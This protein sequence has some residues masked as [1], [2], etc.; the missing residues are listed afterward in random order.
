MK[1]TRWLA[2]VFLVLAISAFFALDLNQYFTLHYLQQSQSD[3]AR[4]YAE[5]PWSMRAAYFVLYLTVAALSLPG[6]ALLTLAGGA[7]FGFWWGLVLVSFAS[8]MGATVSF[9]V[10]RWLL[11]DW[12]Q[13]RFATQLQEINAGVQRAG[14]LYLLSLRL[15]PVV[16]FFLI[17]LTMGLTTLRSWTFYGVSQAGML[18]GT[19]VFVNAGI[20]LGSLQRLSDAA[21]PGLLGSLALIGLMPLVI[22][23]AMRHAEKLRVFAPW[24]GQRPQRFDR[25][26]IVIGAG[27]GGLVSA[28]IAAAVKAKVTLVE[29]RQMGGDCL[30]TGCVPSKALIRSANVAHQMRQAAAF[31]ITP[32]PGAVDFKAVMQRVRQV[33]ADIAPHDSLERYT[34]LGVDVVQGHATITNPW[35]VSIRRP[36]ASIQT[37]TTRSIVIAAGAAPVVPDLPG[38]QASGFL[39]SDTLWDALAG[40]ETLPKRWVVMGGGPIGCELAQAFARLGADV[41]QV[42]MAPRLL[43]REDSEVSAT[44]QAALAAD[45]VQVLTNHQ[46]LRCEQHDGTQVLVVSHHGQEVRLPFDRL[47]CAV[48][49]AARLS[50]YGLE[51]LGIPTDKTIVTDDTL[52][53]LYPNIFAAGDVASPMQLTHAAAHQAWYATVNAL[54]GD[55]K[56]F[57]VNSRAIPHVTFTAPEVAGVGLNE[58]QATERGIAYEVTRYDLNDLDRAIADGVPQGF[59]KVLTV[60][61]KDRILGVTL[62]G[63]HAGELLAEY[64]LAMQHG[65]GL[66]KIL[67][68][69]HSYP[70]LAEANKFAAGQWRRAHQ[71]AALLAWAER[72]HRWRR[73]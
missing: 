48:G 61:G 10:A 58:R 59:V 45:G 56:R 36:D 13:A 40:L 24:R 42:E 28:Y 25:N 9:W 38:L 71:P 35:T 73:G 31:G 4:V 32:A 7:V 68:T 46:A 60:P 72:F 34:A 14:A 19:A 12:V 53:T 23:R 49:R 6:A 33:I 1:A 2:L 20:H 54:V 16:P 52:Q 15:I 50:G 18:I 66:N 64:V 62:V 37:L 44:V 69:V 55:F 26:L 65:L 51:A 11:R 21:S 43:M 3:L 70:T 22:R 27:A 30:N 8:S 5:R 63:A 29:A 67:G 39:T 57:R 41:V 47:L 17:N